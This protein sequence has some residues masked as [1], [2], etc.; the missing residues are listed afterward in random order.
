[1]MITSLWTWPRF[2]ALNLLLPGACFAGETCSDFAD[3]KWRGV[4]LGGA[5]PRV[6]GTTSPH[7]DGR[8]AN[9]TVTRVDGAEVMI[10]TSVLKEV[11]RVSIEVAVGRKVSLCDGLVLGSATF[12]D[13][14]DRLGEVPE[15]EGPTGSE[16]EH[17][18]YSEVYRRGLR[19]ISFVRWSRCKGG[20]DACWVQAESREQRPTLV[21]LEH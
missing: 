6:A 4:V 5:L 10:Y 2:L 8:I 14:S 12:R 21:V 3:G 18:S 19:R 20:R 9:K 11:L 1:M 16:D 15:R 17:V 7:Q 13:I